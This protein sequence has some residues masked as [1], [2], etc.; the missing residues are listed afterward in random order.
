[1]S[2]QIKVYVIPF[3]RLGPVLRGE[4]V[5]SN[6]PGDGQ[7]VAAAVMGKEIGVGVFSASH[8]QV[9]FG[10]MPP[11]VTARLERRGDVRMAA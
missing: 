8:P 5:I 3:D 4:E 1:V 2:G 11:R 10:K 9:Q 7:I 6:M